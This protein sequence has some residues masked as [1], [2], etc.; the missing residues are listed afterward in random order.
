MDLKKFISYSS[1]SEYEQVSGFYAHVYE[2]S[3]CINKEEILD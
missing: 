2:L 3:G 1:G